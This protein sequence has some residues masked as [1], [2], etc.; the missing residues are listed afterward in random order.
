MNNELKAKLQGRVCRTPSG[1][2][3]LVESL[4]DPD[5]LPGQPAPPTKA[6]IRYVGGEKDG[7]IGTCEA[8]ILIPTKQHG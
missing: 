1:V 2:E 5:G 6:K 3:V 7:T 8:S 4:Y